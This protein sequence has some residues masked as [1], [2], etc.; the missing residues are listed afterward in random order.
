MLPWTTLPRT[1]KTTK[2]RRLKTRACFGKGIIETCKRIGVLCLGVR[3][4][5]DGVGPVTFVRMRDVVVKHAIDLLRHG[6]TR[7][8]EFGRVREG[9]DEIRVDVDD[10]AVLASK[11]ES[12][13]R[14][15]QFLP[16]ESRRVETDKIQHGSDSRVES[17]GG[18]S[19][20]RLETEHEPLGQ[21]LQILQH[22]A[23]E[24]EPKAHARDARRLAHQ[25]SYLGANDVI[26]MEPERVA[27]NDERHARGRLFQE[28]EHHIRRLLQINALAA[29]DFEPLRAELVPG[30]GGFGAAVRVVETDR[31]V[32]VRREHRL[33]VLAFVTPFVRLRRLHHDHVLVQVQNLLR[34]G[35]PRV[36]QPSDKDPR[37]C[38]IAH[39]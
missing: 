11:F 3:R 29:V 34:Q 18:A 2:L 14:Q 15:W 39:S 12:S 4:E 31:L 35:R 6:Q 8:S 19:G 7:A 17:L 20:E 23:P 13:P 22:V 21:F 1:R 16:L 25:G 32:F 30:P 10:A 33:V 9:G 5:E 24:R 27:E 28:L 38:T 36:M 26:P 37:R